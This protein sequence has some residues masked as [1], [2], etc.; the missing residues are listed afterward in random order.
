[1]GTLGSIAIAVLVLVLQH[2]RVHGKHAYEKLNKCDIYQ[3]SWV[4]DDS[5][6]LYDSSLCNFIEKAFNCQQNGRPDKHYLKYR[7]QPSSCKLPRFDVED[8]LERLRNKRIMFIGDSLSLNQWQSLT[9][10]V[11]AAS[12]QSEYTIERTGSISSM[13]FL[14]HNASLMLQRNA[15]LVDIVEERRGWVLKLN[16]IDHNDQKAWK[17][18]DVLIFNSWYWWLHTGR[19]QPWDFIQDGDN[20]HEDMDRLVAYEKALKTW[21]RWADKNVDPTKTKVFYQSISPTHWNSTGWGNPEG[22]NCSSETQPL[23]APPYPRSRHPAELIVEKVL[24]NM[25]KPVG[26]LNVTALSRLRKDAHPS[27]YGSGG[28]HGMDCSHWC[29]AGVPDTWNNLLYAEL[30]RI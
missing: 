8:L 19:K 2:D 21:A 12:P 3:G 30:I 7:W 10:M 28:H 11:H 22:K 6:P 24:S 23:I 27:M 15:F 14:S 4:Y 25:S 20:L 29:L 16:S 5:Y 1:M 17:D 9:C 18:S 13:K 26:L